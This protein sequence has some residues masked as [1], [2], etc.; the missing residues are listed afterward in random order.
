MG[1]MSEYS[2]R[3]PRAI[4]SGLIAIVS[5]EPFYRHLYGLFWKNERLDVG[6][7]QSFSMH[8]TSSFSATEERI[9]SNYRFV[10]VRFGFR[11]SLFTNIVCKR[12]KIEWGLY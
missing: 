9:V 4:T 1:R 11:T 8:W 7:S 2:C 10:G 6:H 5:G 3:Q 12:R